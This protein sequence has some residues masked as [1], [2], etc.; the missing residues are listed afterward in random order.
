MHSFL[1]GFNRGLKNELDS[2]NTFMKWLDLINSIFI[3]CLPIGRLI[4]HNS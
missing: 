1:T 2:F 3:T 4:I